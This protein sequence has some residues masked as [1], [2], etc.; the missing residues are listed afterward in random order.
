MQ[1][2][3]IEDRPQTD[4][5]RAVRERHVDDFGVEHFV[6]YMAES[7]ADVEAI[8]PSRAAQIEADLAAAEIAANLAEA[9]GGE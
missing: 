1:S 6:V 8:L 2:T 4:G 5:R 3:I 9:E 7:G